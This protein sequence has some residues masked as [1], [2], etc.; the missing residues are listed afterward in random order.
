[1]RSCSFEHAFLVFL[2][3]VAR[4]ASMNILEIGILKNMGE[5]QA[6]MLSYLRGRLT[7]AEAELA[8][9]RQKLEAEL[10]ITRQTL[11]AELAITRQKL[12]AELAITRQKLETELAITHQRL[13]RTL[14]DGRRLE[15]ETKRDRAIMAAVMRLGDEK[16]CIVQLT[17]AYA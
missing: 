8:I 2:Y 1:M 11:E 10:A 16:V 13:E 5:C 3:L 9:T 4:D 14:A 12:E 15:E 7:S 17:S 6:A